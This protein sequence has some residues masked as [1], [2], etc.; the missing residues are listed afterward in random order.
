[1]EE[2]IAGVDEVGRG[3]L[4]GPVVAAAVILGRVR[5]SEL[6][7][8]KKL[9]E[10]KRSEIAQEIKTKAK[11]ISI[12]VVSSKMIDKI[13]I[14][15][16]SILAMQK[17]AINLSCRPKKIIVDGEDAFESEFPLISMIKADNFIPEV[18]AASI[19]AK[20]YRDELLKKLDKKYP[21]FCFSSH[22]G[23]PTKKHIDAINTY[24]IINEHRKTFGPVKKINE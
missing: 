4:V 1:M 7:D 15:R 24:G 11:S 9:S 2:F 16:A 14:K 23:Y 10:S 5:I 6:K 12:G 3:S 13:N 20:V 18:M 22:K 17:A 19:I 8:S 21:E